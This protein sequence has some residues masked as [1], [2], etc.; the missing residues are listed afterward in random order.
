VVGLRDTPERRLAASAV[1][2]IVDLADTDAAGL[3]RRAVT[4]WAAAGRLHRIHPGVFALGH[5]ELDARGR[6]IA[7]SR[8]GGPECLLTHQSSIALWDLGPWPAVPHIT[9]R[10]VKLLRGVRVHRA[11]ELPRATLRQG[12]RTTTVPQALLDLAEVA[13]EA[14][15]SRTLNEALYRRRTSTA[16]LERF[17]AGCRGR[18]GVAVLR[19][20]IPHAG[21]RHSTLEDEFF[22]LLRKARLPLPEC[23]VKVAG[24]EVDFWWPGPGAVVETDGWAA[25]GERIRFEADRERDAH[26]HAAGFPP[27]RITGHALSTRPFSVIARLGAV[28]LGPR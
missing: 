26:L 16:G 28:I 13:G 27:M 8:A 7:A 22:D 11:R 24:Y 3:S 14:T 15:V 21:P 10:G 25:H 17:L 19:G 20:L 4:R 18:H 12:L 9:T 6:A 1:G 5:P 23:N 2:G